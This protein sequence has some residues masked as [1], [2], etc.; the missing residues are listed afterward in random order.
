MTGKNIAPAERKRIA[1]LLPAQRYEEARG[2]GFP[3]GPPLTE[4]DARDQIVK[5][6]DEKPKTRDEARQ[7]LA[8]SDNVSERIGSLSLNEW[9][10]IFD[11]EW[12]P[13]GNPTNGPAEERGDSPSS[14][15]G[16]KEGGFWIGTRKFWS[17]AIL[18]AVGVVS[19]L[20]YP[21]SQLGAF[22]STAAAIIATL[23]VAIALGAF[24]G[25]QGKRPPL[26]FEHWVFLIAAS[27]GLLAS[28]RGLSIGTSTRPWLTGLT[29]VGVT[30]S[31]LLV[32]ESLVAW[33]AG[34]SAPWWTTL[35]VAIAVLLV[36]VR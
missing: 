16:Y 35:F 34:K 24:A 6:R 4:G 33:R 19:A 29:V 8:P 30:A 11:R 23:Y 20:Q 36:I 7:L 27:A 2:L 18:I 14:Y 3:D 21:H 28:L 15:I 12:P 13:G 17:I 5:A 1:A 32:A 22:Y 9:Q 10:D 26:T 25:Q 31:I